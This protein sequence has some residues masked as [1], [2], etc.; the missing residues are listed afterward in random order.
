MSGPRYQS[1]NVITDECYIWSIPFV[2]HAVRQEHRVIHQVG[3]TMQKG[4]R[5]T[6]ASTAGKK[7]AIIER[8]TFRL[9]CSIEICIKKGDEVLSKQLQVLKPIIMIT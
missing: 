9:H 6:G 4:S 7:K 3:Y 5:M 2:M 8:S 1:I